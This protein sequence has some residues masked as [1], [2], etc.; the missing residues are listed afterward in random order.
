MIVQPTCNHATSIKDTSFDVALH[1]VASQ[2]GACDEAHL[3]VS[4]GY[5]S[6]HSTVRELI[7]LFQPTVEPRGRDEAT[8]LANHW[9]SDARSHGLKSEP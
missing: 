2:V 8:H 6:A 9:P 5:L 3:A 4:H 1:G 7:R